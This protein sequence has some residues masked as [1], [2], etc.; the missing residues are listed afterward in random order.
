MNAIIAISVFAQKTYDVIAYTPPKGWTEKQGNSNIAYS[1]ID[2]GSWAQIAIYK[3]RSSEGDIQTDFDKDWNELVAT[4]R[5]IS[6]P[7]KT[8]PATAKG[9]TVMSGS[10]IWQY[11]GSNV[12]T[13]LTVYTNQKI[14]IALLCNA[15]AAPYLKEYQKLINSLDINVASNAATIKQNPTQAPGKNSIDFAGTWISRSSSNG[16]GVSGYIEN[17][18][19]FNTDGSYSFYSKTFNQSISNLILKK[20]K[21]NFIISGKQI[22]L[23][24]V[25]SITEGWSKKNGIDEFGKLLS[26]QKN[27]LEKATYQFTKY[28]F[29]GIKEW[30]LVLQADKPTIRDGMFSSNTL[31]RNAWYYSMPS[32]NKPAIK[33]P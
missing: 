9:F 31:F 28:F 16:L 17:E 8:E 4:G 19:I 30:S 5:A 2:G 25:T 14:C 32:A 1:R 21:G 12:A 26:S 29:E 18:Y 3:H 24:P 7:E 27:K 20:E 6:A 23:I 10:G 15:T 22:T 11:N 33:L 13:M